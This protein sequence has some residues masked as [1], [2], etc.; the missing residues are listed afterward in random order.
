MDVFSYSQYYAQVNDIIYIKSNPNKA[1]ST[2]NV[3]TNTFI[4]SHTDLDV[5]STGTGYTVNQIIYTCVAATEGYVFIAGG[6]Y[7]ESSS[8]WV[9]ANDVL[10]YDLT[11]DQW[12][13]NTRSMTHPR[14]EHSCI[15]H[16][17]TNELY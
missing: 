14:E 15:I 9:S 16:P 10:V 1:I 6:R 7:C 11:G 17:D 13:Q 5:S 3:K 2:F 4:Q 8:K 12:I